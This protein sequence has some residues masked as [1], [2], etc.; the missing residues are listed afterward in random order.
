MKRYTMMKR[1]LWGAWLA[2]MLSAP[3]AEGK[4]RRD[5]DPSHGS[6]GRHSQSLSAGEAADRAAARHGGR[7]LSVRRAD[8]NDRPHYKVKMLNGGNVW[9]ERIYMDE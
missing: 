8:E 6:S 2:L 5:E 4:D 1:T 7:A 3:L 9:T